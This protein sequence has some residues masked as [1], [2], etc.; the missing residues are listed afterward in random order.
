MWLEIP[1]ASNSN[2]DTVK[3]PFNVVSFF[4]FFPGRF[5]RDRGWKI[6]SWVIHCPLRNFVVEAK[7]VQYTYTDIW[8]IRAHRSGGGTRLYT[9]YLLIYR[10]AV[11]KKTKKKGWRRKSIEW[12]TQ[13][14]RLRLCLAQRERS[15][16]F[17]WCICQ[18]SISP[19][20]SPKSLSRIVRRGGRPESG[21]RRNY[22][23]IDRAHTARPKSLPS[24][25]CLAA[26]LSAISLFL[27]VSI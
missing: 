12:N 7:H 15:S 20:P 2:K 19:V 14:V 22:E 25:D 8:G 3:I 26:N 27:C 24:R 17:D 9:I 18:P 23:A 4:S 11:I 13:T 5:H 21:A 10:K 16:G 6:V 1:R